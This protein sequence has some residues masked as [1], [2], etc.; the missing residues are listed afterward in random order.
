VR[1]TAGRIQNRCL[2]LEVSQQ[3]GLSLIL[4]QRKTTTTKPH[5]LIVN[6]ANSCV[7]PTI[8]AAG[9]ATPTAAT[10]NHNCNPTFCA[11]NERISTLTKMTTVT[12]L[13]VPTMIES[14]H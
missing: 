12:R 13:F 2:P 14:A 9:M 11:N 8:E 3:P 7:F 4:S 10:R 1:R 6:E 5:Q